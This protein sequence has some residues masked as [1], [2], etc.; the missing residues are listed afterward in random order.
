MDFGDGNPLLNNVCLLI[1]I[2]HIWVFFPAD[3]DAQPCKHDM[4][5]VLFKPRLLSCAA[6]IVGSIFVRVLFAL[7]QPKLEWGWGGEGVAKMEAG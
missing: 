4:A 2:G 7:Q 1:I 3:M 5:I 6:V